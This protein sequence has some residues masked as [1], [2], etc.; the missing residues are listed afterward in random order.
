M[1]LEKNRVKLDDDSE[2]EED[3][4]SKDGQQNKTSSCS[5]SS[6]LVSVGN[7]AVEEKRPQL[8][9][10]ELEAKHGM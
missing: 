9:P 7:T 10:E 6:Q 4:E 3:G 8:T 2:E 5:N 1:P